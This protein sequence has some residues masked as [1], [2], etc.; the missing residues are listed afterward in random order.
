MGMIVKVYENLHFP[1][2][3]FQMANALFA[4]IPEARLRGVM[5]A[6]HR[7]SD[8]PL[9]LLDAEGNI[10]CALGELAG[11]CALL[12]R[13]LNT[14][15]ECNALHAKAGARARELG[16]SYIYTCTAGLSH[17]SFPLGNREAL[18]GALVV[19]PFLMEK[20]DSTLISAFVEGRGL[21][22]SRALELY[23]ELFSLPVIEPARVQALSQLLECLLAPLLPAE[24]ALLMQQQEQLDQQSRLNEAIQVYKA[25]QAERSRAGIHE[26]EKALLAKV[27]TGGEAQAKA[28]LNDLMGYVLYCEGGDFAAVRARAL[29]L[30]ALASRAA[31]EGGAGADSIYELSQAYL[32]QLERA[33]D[34]ESLCRLLQEVVGLQRGKA[35]RRTLIIDQRGDLRSIAALLICRL[36]GLGRLLWFSRLLCI[37]PIDNK[38]KVVMQPKR[39]FGALCTGHV[40]RTTEGSVC[41]RAVHQTLCVADQY[42]IPVL[43]GDLRPVADIIMRILVCDDHLPGIADHLAVFSRNDTGFIQ[44]VEQDHRHLIAA[45]R[46]R[47]HSKVIQ[48][49]RQ[50]AVAFRNVHIRLIPCLIR[51]GIPKLILINSPLNHCR[52]FKARDLPLRLE[53]AVAYA[54]DQSTVDC[55]T[56][57]FIGPMVFRHIG[58]IRCRCGRYDQYG[59]QKEYCKDSFHLSFPLSFP[60]L[61]RR[62]LLI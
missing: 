29:E 32:A 40:G 50:Q 21:P 8:L 42:G 1:E 5:G 25:Q 26:R 36:F 60:V 28:L 52:E 56:D 54:V 35:F 61:R 45:D 17:I 31:I 62:V 38:Y 51:L 48:S 57:V 33:K 34:R 13:E 24:R 27:R 20:P 22:M 7:F 46:L 37:V 59:R 53:A 41:I 44:Y 43:R 55:V 12:Q 19:G 49:I 14:W 6:L 39:Y 10:L 58:K 11:C 2:E 47:K 9:R 30:A 4:L 16:G 18:L 3:A 23:D 15:Q